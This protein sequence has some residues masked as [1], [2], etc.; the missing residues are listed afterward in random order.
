MDQ[1]TLAALFQQYGMKMSSFLPSVAFE[2]VY[3]LL[4]TSVREKPLLHRIVC[5]FTGCRLMCNEDS[6]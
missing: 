1:H 2:D 4:G 6:M 5:A 3:W